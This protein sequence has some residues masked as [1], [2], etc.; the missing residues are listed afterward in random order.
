MTTILKW[1]NN[2]Y[3]LGSLLA[4][5]VVVDLVAWGFAADLNKS[6]WASWVQA[7][8]SILAIVGSF[9]IGRSQIEA[10]TRLAKQA[11]KDVLNDRH[12]TIQGAL[13]RAFQVCLNVDEYIRN[14]EKEPVRPRVFSYIKAQV[15]AAQRLLD[16]IPLFELGSDV[17][18]YTVLDFK[19]VM[20]AM[21]SIAEWGLQPGERQMHGDPPFSVHAIMWLDNEVTTARVAYWKAIAITGGEARI[22]PDPFL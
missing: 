4:L 15:P 11:R 19:S 16:E 22:H 8:G 7:I 18:V 12:A 3:V 10:Q 17:L 13:D 6:E 20:Q 2:A 14:P 21:L 5:G 1:L 9:W